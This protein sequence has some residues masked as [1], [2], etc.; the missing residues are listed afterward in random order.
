MFLWFGLGLWKTRWFCRFISV[1]LLQI[2]RFLR[3]D[4]TICLKQVPLK[5]IP[6]NSTRSE[7][8]G[9][10][11]MRSEATN[12]SNTV[13]YETTSLK[14]DEFV[15]GT[16]VTI[17][18]HSR[19]NRA[20]EDNDSVM[21]LYKTIVTCSSFSLS[22]ILTYKNRHQKLEFL[23]F[24]IHFQRWKNVQRKFI[25]DFDFWIS[26]FPEILDPTTHKSE[27]NRKLTAFFKT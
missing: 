14:W 10:W 1:N 7:P 23:F 5:I 21:N 22:L 11:P 8:I 17:E 27:S 24:Q 19:R 15:S 26:I 12:M 20:I 16:I 18:S 2:D 25:F 3:E 13:C 9:E 6:S 4:E